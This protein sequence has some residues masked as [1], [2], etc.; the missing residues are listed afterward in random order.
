MIKKIRCLL[1]LI[2][3]KRSIK[4]KKNLQV[5]NNIYNDIAM[6]ITGESDKLSLTY[7]EIDYLTFS[8]LL[9]SIAPKPNDVFIDLGSGRAK[10][11]FAAALSFNVQNCIGIE[12]LAKRHL[13]A[14]QAWQKAPAKV[15]Q[16]VKLIC[17]DFLLQSIE[18]ATI[19]FIN[20]TG[21]FNDEYRNIEQLL[22]SQLRSGARVIITSKKL[23]LQHFFL[24]SSNTIEM[25][26]GLSHINIY[27]KK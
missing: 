1:Q 18:S 17:A 15:Q 26:Y 16:Q 9:Y 14:Q 25:D 12:L 13:L 23:S 4:F 21:F 10:A 11:C 20:A 24:L 22:T 2:K 8:I 19:I 5:F 27:E 6:P 3:V 7:G